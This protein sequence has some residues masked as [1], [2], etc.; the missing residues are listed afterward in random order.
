M[1]PEG[2]E[3]PLPKILSDVDIYQL[4]DPAFKVCLS[5]L[6]LSNVW[7]YDQMR[8]VWERIDGDR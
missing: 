1:E 7:H 4:G 2:A 8:S 3:G 6:E 5:I